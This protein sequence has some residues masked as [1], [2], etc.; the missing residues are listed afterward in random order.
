M[1]EI[2]LLERQ[3]QEI[4]KPSLKQVLF[5]ANPTEFERW[6][7][8][9][10]RQSALIGAYVLNRLAPQYK[11]AVWDGEFD[12]IIY[13]KPYRYRHAWIYGESLNGDKDIFVDLS[14]QHHQC[15]FVEVTENK[16]PDG[17]GYDDMKELKR[18]QIDWQNF[19]AQPEYYTNVSGEVLGNEM[20][21]VISIVTN[22]RLKAN[23]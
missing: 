18:E 2:E 10:C 16:Y 1:T 20:L 3:M 5:L 9:H 19:I 13:G 6:Q 12:D 14:R 15:L 11:W 21:Q 23:A 8:N 4:F 17:Y 22:D 7:G